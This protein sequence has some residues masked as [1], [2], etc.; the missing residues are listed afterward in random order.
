MEVVRLWEKSR[1]LAWFPFPEV[2]E[3]YRLSVNESFLQASAFLFSQPIGFQNWCAEKK[4][5]LEDLSGLSKETPN[6]AV[7]LRVIQLGLHKTEGLEAMK[8]CQ[9]LSALKKTSD[10]LWLHDLDYGAAEWL[11]HLRQL[12]NPQ[13]EQALSQL[14]W[15]GTSQ[16]R[17][18]HHEGATGIEVKLFVSQPRDLEKYADSFEKIQELLETTHGSLWKKH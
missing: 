4:V 6:K 10:E 3:K 18:I 15:P 12:R 16:V 11:S 2:A 13:T 5:N 9:E 14:P 8:L 17:W 1:E 7:Q